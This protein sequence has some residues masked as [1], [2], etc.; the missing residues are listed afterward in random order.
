[1]LLAGTRRAPA[2]SI[3]LPNQHA[4]YVTHIA[5]DI[6]GSLIKLVYFSPDPDSDPEHEQDLARAAAANAADAAAAAG[7]VQQAT[8]GGVG[9]G[10]ASPAGS[11]PV[12]QQPGGANGPARGGMFVPLARMYKE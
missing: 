7:S 6:G 5:L 2:P 9:A 11:V 4:E 1:M 8:S 12:L 10:A 3:S